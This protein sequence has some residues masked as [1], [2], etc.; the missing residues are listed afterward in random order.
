MTTSAPAAQS[1]ARGRQAQTASRAG[2]TVSRLRREH[3]RLSLGA[4]AERAVSAA[5]LHQDSGTR[6]RVTD[7]VAGSHGH[8][9]AEEQR[10]GLLEATGRAQE[11]GQELRRTRHDLE[12]R[13]KTARCG[14]R[15]AGGRITG[16]QAELLGA[17]LPLDCAA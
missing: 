8:H 10:P 9:D 15:C 1:A 3:D 16:L 7:A 14:L 2:T 6:A 12:Q 13:P 17:R 11:A 5:F 4:I